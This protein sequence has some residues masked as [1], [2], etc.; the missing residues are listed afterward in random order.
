MNVFLGTDTCM[1]RPLSYTPDL[2]SPSLLSPFLHQRPPLPSLPHPLPSLT[3]SP[4]FLSSFVISVVAIYSSLL[5]SR[6]SS[7]H[8]HPPSF[9]SS[10]RLIALTDLLLAPILPPSFGRHGNPC[11]ESLSSSCSDEILKWDS[12]STL[13]DVTSRRREGGERGGVGMG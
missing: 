7:F 6:P 1:H 4:P 13:T 3:H 8:L 10:V 11:S 9:R 12:C 2:L 5:H